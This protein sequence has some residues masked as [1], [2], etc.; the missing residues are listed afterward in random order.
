MSNT[1][2]F[3]VDV[4]TMEPSAPAA[5]DVVPFAALKL[6]GQDES[7]A[8]DQELFGTFSVDSLMEL[9]GL[10]VAEVVLKCFPPSTHPRVLVVVGPGNNGGDGLVAARHLNHF[11]YTHPPPVVF[12][13]K[14]RDTPLFNNLRKQNE[15]LGNTV[16]A[17]PKSFELNE[18]SFDVVVDAV[19]GFSFR[20]E[21][22]P[23]FKAVLRDMMAKA[24]SVPIVSV[25]VPSG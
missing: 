18:E 15:A 3:Y 11:G 10:S 8:I 5:A 12:Y 14:Q 1:A 19:F 25:D 7:I 23:P 21:P 2:K 4:L 24:T 6:V 9:A 22:R 17:D 20:G 16:L 13:P